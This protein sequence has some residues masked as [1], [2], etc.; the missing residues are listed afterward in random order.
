MIIGM[1]TEEKIGSIVT[2]T[3]E[4]TDKERVVAT[5]LIVRESSYEEWLAYRDSVNRPLNHNIPEERAYFYEVLT[6]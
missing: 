1:M 4:I 5:F 3:Y 6:D 2:G